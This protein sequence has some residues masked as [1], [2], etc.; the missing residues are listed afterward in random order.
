MKS[1]SEFCMIVFLKNHQQNQETEAMNVTQKQKIE[2]IKNHKKSLLGQ[3][4]ETELTK[5]F[6]SENCQKI[7]KKP[8]GMRDRIYTTAK[9][10]FT[11]IKQV[12]DSDKSCRNA[13]F[14]VC[15]EKII[16]GQKIGCNTGSY[17]RARTKLPENDVHE[18]VNEVGK[19]VS[20]ALPP[21]WKPLHQRNLKVADGTTLTASDTEENQKAFPQHKNQKKRMW[22]S[23]A[24][25]RCCHVSGDRLCS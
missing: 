15:A 24:P 9:T 21:E 20:K 16:D 17:C 14:G 5:I 12:L 3:N 6:N 18:L 4:A 13:V 1:V 22:F 25:R 23:L 8:A 11:F 19:T 10:V 7:L 2:Q